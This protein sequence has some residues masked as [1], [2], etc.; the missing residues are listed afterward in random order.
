MYNPNKYYNC[1]NRNQHPN[2]VKH[3]IPSDNRYAQVHPCLVFYYNSS[4]VAHHTTHTILL[5]NDKVY[6]I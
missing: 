5:N 2:I 6:A 3:V 1:S 4:L